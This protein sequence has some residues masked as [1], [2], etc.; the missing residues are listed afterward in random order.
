MAYVPPADG[1]GDWATPKLLTAGPF[2]PRGD[3]T[4]FPH[5]AH[6]RPPFQGNKAAEAG[7]NGVCPLCVAHGGLAH[8]QQKHIEDQ[9]RALTPFPQR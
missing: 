7:G 8:D 4:A 1:F 2:F 5:A 9:A 3:L 6:A